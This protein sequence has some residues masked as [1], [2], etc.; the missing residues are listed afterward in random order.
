VIFRRTLA[1]VEEAKAGLA[2]AAPRRRGAGA[3][4]AE[5]MAAFDQGLREAEAE[6]P[7]WRQPEVE[8]VWSRCQAA[9]REA[10][11]KAERFRLAD[12]PEGYEALYGELADLMEPLDAFGAALERFRELG[13]R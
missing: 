3:P 12:P 5:A 9:V 13:L 1:V 8:D 6:M 7:G 4:L 2:A 10:A 11:A